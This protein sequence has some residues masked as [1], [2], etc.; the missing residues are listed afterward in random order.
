MAIYLDLKVIGLYVNNPIAVSNFYF[1]YCIKSIGFLLFILQDIVSIYYSREYKI[2][3]YATIDKCFIFVGTEFNLDFQVSVIVSIYYIQ[4]LCS[5]VTC[6]LRFYRQPC[7]FFSYLL[8]TLLICLMFFF[9][10]FCNYYRSSISCLMFSF[11]VTGFIGLR[12]YLYCFSQCHSLSLL[13]T[14][15]QHS[16]LLHSL[17]SVGWRR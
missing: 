10:I 12:I 8:R 16:S 14:Y 17:Y 5:V 1:I 2:L 13:S 6:C 11:Q 7:Q 15:T 3:L 4:V 9:I